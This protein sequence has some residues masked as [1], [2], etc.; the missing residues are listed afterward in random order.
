MSPVP[1]QIAEAATVDLSGLQLFDQPVVAEP[2]APEAPPV[3][4]SP[5][6]PGTDDP[7]TIPLEPSKDPSP[8]PCRKPGDDDGWET[9]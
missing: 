1:A 5:T 4:P 2:A 8:Q 7:A 6:R 3:A 9:C